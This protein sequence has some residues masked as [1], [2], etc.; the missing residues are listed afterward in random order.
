MYTVA[1][2]DSASLAGT[3]ARRV[4]RPAP[5]AACAGSRA[6]RAPAWSAAHHARLSPP[7]H[8]RGRT[9]AGCVVLGHVVWSHPH[10]S[11]LPEQRGRVLRYASACG[12]GERSLT[13]SVRANDDTP[14]GA[15]RR[16]RGRA[17]DGDGAPPIGVTPKATLR[18]GAAL[19]WRD[20]E[21]GHARPASRP[22]TS[23]VDDG[24]CA[25][26]SASRTCTRAVPNHGHERRDP[27]AR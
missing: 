27:P 19:C 23:R 20:T 15:L 26:W 21:R 12:T 14:C 4:G 9:P 16:C 2:A 6:A 25:C 13:G 11:H 7:P 22:A 8:Q 24:R 3:P 1:A 17:P 18:H 5:G 10:A